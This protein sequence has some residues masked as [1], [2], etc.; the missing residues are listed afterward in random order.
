VADDVPDDGL[1]SEQTASR[2]SDPEV[3][4]VGAATVDRHYAVSN[5][6]EPDGG[7]FADEVTDRF[8]GVAANVATACA[9]LGRAAGLLTRVGEDD[10]GDRVLADLREGPLDLTRLRRADDVSTHCLVLRDDAGRRSIVTAGDSVRNLRLDAADRPYL[11]GADVVFVT[12]YAPDAVHQQLLSW[13]EDPSFPPVVFDLSGPLSELAGRGATRASIDAWVDRAAVFVVGRVAAESYLGCA[14]R[15]AAVELAARG[16]DRAAVTDGD[17]GATLVAPAEESASNEST[18]TA[19][20]SVSVVDVSEGD[21]KRRLV[22]HPAFDVS[23]VDETGA[24]DAYVAGLIH[25]W[26]LNGERPR[27]SG[28]VA[29]AT[30]AINC[31]AVGARGDLPTAE[32]VTAFRSRR[33]TDDDND[34]TDDGETDDDS[35]ETGDG[36]TDDDNDEADN[37]DS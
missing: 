36:E 23:V 5:L 12:A 13:A 31:T 33:S 28:S 15:D 24:G 7:A 8:G 20:E 4:T 21:E 22:A 34:E 2:Q 3:V 27:V 32:R 37:S 18:T 30:A 14:G 9:R 16:V 11:A 29:A 17:D 6:P 35:D 26:L 1:P 25:A 10:V 19:D